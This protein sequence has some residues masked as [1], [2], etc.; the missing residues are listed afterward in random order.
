MCNGAA[1]ECDWRIV[2]APKALL[3]HA[4]AHTHPHT[5]RIPCTHRP[6]CVR[7][8]ARTHSHSNARRPASVCGRARTHTRVHART[9]TVE[10]ECARRRASDC[11]KGRACSRPCFGR[12]GAKRLGSARGSKR[13]PPSAVDGP[14]G[15]PYHPRSA[16]TARRPARMPLASSGSGRLSHA[17]A[18]RMSG[19]RLA[20][21]RGG[22]ASPAGERKTRRLGDSGRACARGRARAWAACVRACVGGWL[23]EGGCAPWRGGPPFQRRCLSG[24][25]TLH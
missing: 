22:G 9:R 17:L 11:G 15:P 7:T 18:V 2:H 16:T 23:G 20:G 14:R 4:R 5:D 19:E 13:P 6:Q 21:G 8:H 24:A 1:V 3:G 10:H 12:P 25:T